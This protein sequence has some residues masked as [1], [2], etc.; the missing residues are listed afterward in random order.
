MRV[1][2]LV[3]EPRFPDPGIADNRD[4][5]AA[6][7]P[8]LL[9]RLTHLLH[10][11]VAAHEP[12]Q[13]PRASGLQPRACRAGADELEDLD[14]LRDTLDRGGPERSHLH[15]AFRQCHRVR[16]QPCRARR[17]ELLHPCGEVGRLADRRVVHPQI[18]ADRADHHVAR[19]QA[20]A[21]LHLDAL[22][23]AQL[24]R[25]PADRVVHAERRIARAHRVILVRKR[26]AE[27]RHD[28][29]AHHLVHRA[30]VAMHRVHHVREDGI[31]NLARFLGI[32]VGEQLHRSLQVG[33]EDGDQLALALQR[34]FG[35]EDAIREMLRRVGV[36]RG[37]A[38]RGLRALCRDTKRTAASVAELAARRIR[39]PA[40][41]AGR[42]EPM[43]AM[44]AEARARGIFTSTLRTHRGGA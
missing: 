13:P 32:A 1:Q 7:L 6:A 18:A 10:L 34:R 31:E 27:E 29:V 23:P 4:Q 25:V 16:R 30:L 5:L 40:R 21:D 42:V 8:R 12:S 26:R 41:R 22:R 3:E 39:L 14:G 33:E 37:K 20:H 24:L 35:R 36:G 44:V 19:V 43:T 15:E 28:P 17:G 9:G 2:E 11:D 38:R